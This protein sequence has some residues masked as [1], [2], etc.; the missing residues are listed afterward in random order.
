V[1]GTSIGLAQKPGRNTRLS[2]LFEGYVSKPDIIIDD[3]P[4]TAQTPLVYRVQDEQWQLLAE[5]IIQK[6]VD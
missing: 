5:R 6:H 1:G 4:S 2:E 3:M